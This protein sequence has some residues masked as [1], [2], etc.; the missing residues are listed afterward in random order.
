MQRS[1]A[2]AVTGLALIVTSIILA[3]GLVVA[4]YVAVAGVKYVKTFS[5]TQLQVTGSAQREVTSD[6]VKWVAAIGRHVDVSQLR[7]GYSSMA[8]DLAAAIDILGEHGFDRDSLSIGPVYVSSNYNDCYNQ[9]PDCVRSVQS[10]DFSQLFTLASDDVADVTALAQDVRPFVDRG[11]GL[12]TQSLEYYYSGLAEARPE[13]LA[14]ATKDAQNRAKAIAD[15]TGADVGAL[16]SV[17]SGVFQVTQVN[18]VDVESYGSYDT[19][20][21]EKKITAVVH[22]RFALRP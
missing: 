19:S 2:P 8:D 12:Q 17:D 9:G 11:I 16:Q 10:Y 15:S 13:L 22:A 5:E 7:Q 20:T 1:S 4:A 18:S 14:E 3:A 6:E 21:I